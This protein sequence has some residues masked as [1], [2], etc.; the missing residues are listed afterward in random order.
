MLN[1]KKI[2]QC[3]VCN[4]QLSPFT[5]LGKIHLSGFFAKNTYTKIPRLPLNMKICINY[6][7][8]LVQLS[9]NYSLKKLFGQDYGYRS[10]LNLSMI[11]HLKDIYRLSL[12]LI[13]NNYQSQKNILDIGS[14]DGT[15]L[16][17][18]PNKINKFAVDPTINKFKKYYKKDIKKFSKFFN[19]Q[20][21][22]YFVKKKLKFDLIFTISM[23]YDLPDPNTF[24]KN[25]SKILSSNGYWIME[26]SYLNLMLKQNS[27]D[28]ICHEHLEYYSIKSLTYLL[29]KHNLY[30]NNIKFNDINGGSFQ[31]EIS[32]NKKKSAKISK[33]LLNEKKINNS[34]INN[35]NN[36]IK[37]IKNRV[38]K[39]INKKLNYYNF[40]VYGASTKGNIIISYFN[41]N[42]SI[43]KLALDVNKEKNNKY[44][45]GSKILITNDLNKVNLSNSIFF[46]NIWHFKKFILL[47]E[48][49]LLKQGAKFLFPLPTPHIISIKNNRIIKRY[50]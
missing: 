37:E 6:K 45:P 32:K 9:H 39:F 33:L 47:K 19:S 25:L 36:R 16:N 40:Y 18:F 34:I 14:N 22:E 7:C 42:N 15:L 3:R 4:S 20:I 1:Y 48:Q 2:N 41:L 44:T 26:N 35:F 8:Q 38:N 12:K 17:F 31:I 11:N 10:G 21:T 46:V 23:F 43:F 50:I 13:T 49:K 29:N 24:V 27:F 5:D 30:I 28:T